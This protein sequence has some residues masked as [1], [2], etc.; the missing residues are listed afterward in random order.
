T[1][2]E[3]VG[4]LFAV[5]LDQR[6]IAVARI[7]EPLKGRVQLSGGM[8]LNEADQL[9]VLLRAG[10]LPAKLVTIEQQLVAPPAK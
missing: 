10:V 4:Q 8:G 7:D 2:Q 3:H 9:S 5:V 1:T 6:P